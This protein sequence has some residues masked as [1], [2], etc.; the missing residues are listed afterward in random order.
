MPGPHNPLKGVHGCVWHLS[1]CSFYSLW[2]S[3]PWRVWKLGGDANLALQLLPASAKHTRDSPCM[4]RTLVLHV[5]S[6]PAR[7]TECQPGELFGF[8][9][10]ALTVPEKAPQSPLDR[11]PSL[12]MSGERQKS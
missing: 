10:A 12:M 4:K 11:E 7:Q 5:G 3:R 1:T 6:F 8:G 9:S 2:D